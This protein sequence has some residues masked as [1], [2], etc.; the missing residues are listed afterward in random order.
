MFWCS[1]RRFLVLGQSSR[2]TGGVLAGPVGIPFVQLQ[3]HDL[4]VAGEVVNEVGQRD[5]PGVAHQ[6]DAVSRITSPDAPL[7]ARCARGTN[8]DD[9]NTRF[10]EKLRATIPTIERQIVLE[11][12]ATEDGHLPSGLD[13]LNLPIVHQVFQFVEQH[14]PM[15][16]DIVH[17]QTATLEPIFQ[18]F[19]QLYRKGSPQKFV[20]KDG[21]ATV[22][23]YQNIGSLSFASS[24]KQPLIRASDF[25]L[26]S[27]KTFVMLALAEK[28]IPKDITLAAAPY[29]GAIWCSV[30]SA[31]HPNELE[32]FPHL[33]GVLASTQWVS[34]V[35]RRFDGE[36]RQ[37]AGV[38]RRGLVGD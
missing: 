21:R 30:L 34:T 24:A 8:R 14:C 27:I 22:T 15:P 18:Y 6:A 1:G 26:A 16:C 11:G 10:S 7:S 35:F 12:R 23:G 28:P 5:G 20:M 3:A 38:A 19:F 36:F 4:L 13:S 25:S 37:A 33:G 31:M 9:G 32:P 29:L 17:D 2:R